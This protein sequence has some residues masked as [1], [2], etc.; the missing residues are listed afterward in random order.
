M[1][2]L[3]IAMFSVLLILLSCPVAMAEDSVSFEFIRLWGED[4]FEI[5]ASAEKDNGEI[6]EVPVYL[7]RVEQESALSFK[8]SF[9]RF[10]FRPAKLVEGEDTILITITQN[11]ETG[12]FRIYWGNAYEEVFINPF[13]I[14]LTIDLL[15]RI[16]AI[17]FIFLIIF[18]P[19]EQLKNRKENLFLQCGALV[20]FFFW[21]VFAAQLCREFFPVESI[22]WHIPV[23]LLM[24]CW[25]FTVILA[26]KFFGLSSFFS[27][28]F[29]S[30]CIWTGDLVLLYGWESI[31]LFEY[32]AFLSFVFVASY[33]SREYYGKIFAKK[34]KPVEM[35]RKLEYCW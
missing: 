9:W 31:P 17:V 25:L 23:I 26:N 7:E 20:F 14:D 10:P 24:A 15:W 19:S 2:K 6:R 4:V 32:I 34:Q 1:K 33:L 18:S 27:S 29:F 28:M 16:M 8:S 22:Y 21:S 3:K 30:V 13:F 35:D 12:G 5:R 11:E